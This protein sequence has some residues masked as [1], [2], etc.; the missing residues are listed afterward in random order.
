MATHS[1]RVKKPSDL[2]V[3]NEKSFSVNKHKKFSPYY[4]CCKITVFISA[5]K[6]LEKKNKIFL[7]AQSCRSLTPSATWEGSDSESFIE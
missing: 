3:Q 1:K 2:C 4:F 7:Q 5:G 6:S